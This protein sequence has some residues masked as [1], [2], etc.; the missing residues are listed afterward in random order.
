MSIFTQRRRI[1]NFDP[2]M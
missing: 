2:L 1:L